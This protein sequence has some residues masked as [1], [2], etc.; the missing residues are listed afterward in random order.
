MRPLRIL[1]V[2]ARFTPYVGGTE[3]HTREVSTELTK[4]GHEVTVL[5]TDLGGTLPTNEVVDGVEVVRVRAWPR[6]FDLYLAPGMRSYISRGSWDVVHVQGYHTAVAPL[7]LMAAQ[8]EG[9]PTALTFHSG[10]HG[11]RLRNLGRPIQSRLLG[12]WLR[13]CELLIG[14]SDFEVELFAQRLGIPA[15]RIRMIPNGVS[16]RSSQAEPRPR[17]PA[18]PAPHLLSIGRLQRYKGHHRVI[19]ALPEVAT[20][21]PDV[22]LTILGQGPYRKR[23]EKLA[24]RLGVRDRVVFDHVG[25]DERHRLDEIMDSASA[26]LFLSEYESHGMAA[27][28]ALRAGLPTIV[29]NDTALR[30]LASGGLAQAIP[31]GATDAEVAAIIRRTLFAGQDQDDPTGSMRQAELDRLQQ[32]WPTITSHLECAYRQIADSAVD[33]ASRRRLG[34]AG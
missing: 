13:R 31:P 15:D 19:R 12:R 23:L 25:V 24:S 16:T 28:E 4:R 18:D 11:S 2:S 34:A 20:V 6:R 27:H 1:Q 3:I 22:R 9:I 14:V 21:H 26:A 30:D 33:P 5:T 8:R 7:A 17:R 32:T 29:V 10:G